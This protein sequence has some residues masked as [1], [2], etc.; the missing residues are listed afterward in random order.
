MPKLQ[1]WLQ[2]LR[3]LQEN[4]GFTFN[5]ILRDCN[6]SAFWKSKRFQDSKSDALTPRR[7]T[8]ELLATS[9]HTALQCFSHKRSHVVAW[10][11][12]ICRLGV[13]IQFY[14][15]FCSFWSQSL[16][17]GQFWSCSVLLGVLPMEP[18]VGGA[19]MTR[20]SLTI[21]LG[22]LWPPSPT[23]GGWKGG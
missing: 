1:V 18:F 2:K 3:I 7:S 19:E 8:R 11:W 23:P 12:N 6:V 4:C 16:S 17:S 9:L 15:L 14:C 21:I 20:I 22:F 13:F 5:N 10:K